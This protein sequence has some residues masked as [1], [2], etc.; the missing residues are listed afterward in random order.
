MHLPLQTVIHSFCRLTISFC[1]PSH[2]ELLSTRCLQ[3]FREKRDFGPG[4]ISPERSWLFRAPKGDEFS[5]AV[6]V[7]SARVIGLIKEE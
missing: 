2:G 5:F 3:S 4:L 6:T 7:E 1:L